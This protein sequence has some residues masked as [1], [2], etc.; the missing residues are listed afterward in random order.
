MTSESSAGL[1]APPSALG[2][3]ASCHTDTQ[4]SVA[5]ASRPSSTA[6]PV[7]LLRDACAMLPAWRTGRA[8]LII[9]QAEAE[10]SCGGKTSSE[11]P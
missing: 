6:R 7:T 5:Q 4:S 8:A 2:P 11:H 3:S 10:R 1:D 9:L